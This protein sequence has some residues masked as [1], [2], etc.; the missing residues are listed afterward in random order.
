M[1]AI[2][3]LL[4]GIID[5]DWEIKKLDHSVRVGHE[6]KSM[7]KQ[8]S[9]GNVFDWILLKKSVVGAISAKILIDFWYGAEKSFK[10]RGFKKRTEI[11][12]F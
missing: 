9:K 6:I 3:T 5:L 7:N 10:V 1:L 8:A 2:I 11:Y 12:C 4:V